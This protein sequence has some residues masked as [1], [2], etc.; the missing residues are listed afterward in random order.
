MGFL[1]K[2]R[3]RRLSKLEKERDR[4]LLEEYLKT[5]SPSVIPTGTAENAS[6]NGQICAARGGASLLG[7]AQA[8]Y[9]SRK[10]YID[11]LKKRKALY[12]GRS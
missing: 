10:E 6:M 4:G 8:R 3:V 1:G 7:R 2:S 5:S 11:K 12:K 9:E